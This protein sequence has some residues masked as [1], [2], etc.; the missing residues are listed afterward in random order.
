MRSCLSPLFAPHLIA[1]TALLV[2]SCGGGELDSL[3]PPGVATAAG[4]A[5]QGGTGTAGQ[6]GTT[7][8]TSAGGATAGSGGGGAGGGVGGAGGPMGV[9]GT[10]GAGGLGGAGGVAGTGGIGGAGLGG[11]GGVAGVAGIGGAAGLGGAGGVAGAGGIGGVG[12][13]GGVAGVGGIGG[14]AGGAGLGGTA[15]SPALGGMGGMAGI[16][17]LG[18]SSS[19]GGEAQCGSAGMSGAGGASGDCEPEETQAVLASAQKF[20]V[21]GASTVTNA[22]ATVI[23]G[24]VGVSPGSATSGLPPGTVIHAADPVAAQAQLDVTAAY[25]NLAAEPCDMPLTGTDLGG[26]TLVP[27]TYCFT[28]SAALGATLTLDAQGDPNAVFIFQ[29]QSTLV[30][31]INSTVLVING[32]NDCNVF[33]QVGSSATLSGGTTMIGNVIAMASITAEKLTSVS[34]RLFARTGAVTLDGNVISTAK[35]Q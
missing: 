25:D 12:G 26:L 7:G 28:G 5:G 35:C 30:T 27:G 1:C 33:W 9:G 10:V 3:L 31:T 8:G 32:G 17:A 2:I 29:I 14:V 22:D 19:F 15:G 18:G 20:A 24:E 34:G 13:A 16:G 6:P 11:A 21:L 4:G 23:V